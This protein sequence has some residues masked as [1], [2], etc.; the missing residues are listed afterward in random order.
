MVRSRFRHMYGQ[1]LAM[2]SPLHGSYATACRCVYSFAFNTFPFATFLCIPTF[3]K[4]AGSSQVNIYILMGAP[5]PVDY[6]CHSLYITC[7][8]T[9]VIGMVRISCL[10]AFGKTLSL[11]S[12]TCAFDCTP[13][14]VFQ[15]FWAVILN[16][17]SK[18][19]FCPQHNT[20]YKNHVST[21]KA[22]FHKFSKDSDKYLGKTNDF[23]R[24]IHI[25]TF[26]I[27]PHWKFDNSKTHL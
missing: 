7:F 14:V 10:K 13:I 15:L 16:F 21:P 6:L 9:C 22:F 18:M 27:S 8:L 3:F 11:H 19:C 1:K 2:L 26:L 25:Q 5:L 4:P 24:E 20:C 17:F 12:K 23:L